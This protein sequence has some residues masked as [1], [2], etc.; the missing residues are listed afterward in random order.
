[1][2]SVPGFK[3]KRLILKP[4]SLDDIPSYE[5]HFIDY[6]VIRHLSAVVPLPYPRNGVSEFFQTCFFL[7]RGSVGGVGGY[8]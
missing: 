8:F 1:M 4:L 2:V 5:T 3:T 6:E 7:R